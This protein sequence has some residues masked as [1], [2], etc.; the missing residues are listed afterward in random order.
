M[1]PCSV[2]RRTQKER[3]QATT[4]QL[5][6]AARELFAADGYRATLLDDIVERARVTKGAL[7]HHF[8]GKAELFEA[9]YEEEQRRLA[10][11]GAQAYARKR[12]RWEGLYE[13]CCAFFEASADP[14][15]AQI[16]LIDAPGVLGWERLRQIEGRHTVANLRAGL[17]AAIEKGRV[18]PRPLE[19]IVQMLNGAMCEAAMLAARAPDRQA[20]TQQILGELRLMLDALATP[21]RRRAGPRSRA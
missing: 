11:A 1:Y 9:V 6:E 12:D 10:E 21:P 3:S 15:V 7:Y 8:E 2:P 16:T 5:V 4:R 17:A 13:A 19:P 18:A 20:V 14:G